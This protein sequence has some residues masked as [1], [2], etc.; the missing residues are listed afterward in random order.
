MEIRTFEAFS[1]KDAVKQVKD[2]FGTDAVI[3]ETKTKPSPAGSGRIYEVTAAPATESFSEASSTSRRGARGSSSVDK[4]MIIDWQRKLNHFENRLDEI[5]NKSIRR[6]H[7]ISM[8]SSIEEVRSVLLDYLSQKD[9]SSY[10][11][12]HP[13]IADIVKRLKIMNLDEDVISQLSKHLTALSPDPSKIEDAFEFYQGQAIRWMMKRIKI[14]PR[15]NAMDGEVQVH[16]F[17]GPSGAGKSS[18]VCKLAAEYHLNEKRKVLLVSFDNRRLG[19]AEQMRLYAKVL[20]VPFETISQA[21]D[22]QTVINRHSSCEIVLL[23]T[24]GRSPKSNESIDELSLLSDNNYN[25]NYHLVLSMTDQKT[26][27]ERSIKAFM[28]LGVS[29]LMFTKMDESWTY[30]EV[31][32]AMYKWGIPISWFGV[33]H[34]IPEDL[35]RASRERIVERIIGL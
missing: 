35:E 29:S 33:G 26:Q 24:A 16:T 25:H 3:L 4:E 9:E 17:I 8:E 20:G 28:G 32:N 10:K 5:Y 27:V 31:F 18:I 34:K 2:T 13:K 22:L 11:G 1:M 14:S 21:S 23:D 12:L 7:L 30:G 6:E 15:W 19:A